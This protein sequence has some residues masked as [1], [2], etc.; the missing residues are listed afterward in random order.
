MPCILLFTVKK[1]NI[2]NHI[3]TSEIWNF[4]YK[5]SVQITLMELAGV[6]NSISPRFVFLRDCR[7]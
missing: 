6:F 5:E 7:L 4:K 3:G 2:A 1:A